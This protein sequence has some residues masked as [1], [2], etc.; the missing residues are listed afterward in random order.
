MERYIS[1]CQQCGTCCIKGGP[2]LHKEDLHLIRSRRIPITSLITIRQGELVYKPHISEPEAAACELIK[3]GGTGK[4]WQ[5]RYFAGDTKTCTIYAERPLSCRKLECW[6]T[7]AV[8]Q[9][10]EKDTLERADI[11][12]VDDP[13]YT[14]M[15]EHENQ[16]KY[17]DLLVLLDSIKKRKEIKE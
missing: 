17:P 5:C 3:I 2:A 14:L 13:I 12:E 9:L 6:N 16:C 8:E 15:I 10:V 1:E 11:I 7:D 4:G